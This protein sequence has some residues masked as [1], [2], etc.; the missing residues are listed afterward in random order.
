MLYKLTLEPFIFSPLSVHELTTK[1]TTAV[2]AFLSRLGS[3][4]ILWDVVW[5]EI[6]HIFKN[7][8]TIYS[9]GHACGQTCTLCSAVTNFYFNIIYIII[10]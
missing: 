1:H 7:S 5:G 6:V 2:C 9:A 4:A 10:I 3:L 8:G